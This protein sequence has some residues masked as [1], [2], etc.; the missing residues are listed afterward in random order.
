MNRQT[1]ERTLLFERAPYVIGAASIVAKAEREGPLGSS[2]DRV[3]EDDTFG[4]DSFEKAECRMFETA[5]RDACAGAGL[6]TFDL[7]ALLGGDLLNQ[8]I[9]AN[10]AA[11]NLQ[12][13]FLGLYGACSTMAESLL[14]GGVLADGGYRS[15]VACVACSHF[16]T[17]ER[18]YRYPL[19]MGTTAAPT[20]QRTVTGAGCLLLSDRLLPDV[21]Y[22]HIRVRSAT[23]GKV[24]DLGIDDISNMGAA[25][26]P[27][28]CDTIAQHLMDT[29]RAASDFDR[30][31][32]GDLGTF[33][34]EM[35]LEL[36]AQNGIE[37]EARHF[38]CGE[39][40]Y[41]SEQNYN[42]RGSG[43]GCSAVVLAGH[44]LPYLE[45]GAWKRILFLATGALMS[46]TSNQQGETIPGIA[47][48][49]VLEH[50]GEVGL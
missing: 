7:A 47:H 18:Q 15:P 22:R 26:A 31:V 46:T 24:I 14:L 48:A 45:S 32:T 10:Y 30:I 11:R 34:S 25:M 49:I 12:I 16:S 6:D 40:I 38:D 44:L 50:D 42:C 1:G 29:G 4:E 17:A 20:A 2:F 36:A 43:C 3:L 23:I 27:A 33:G 41:A 8:I 5:V 9:T 19:E 13:P 39:K 28:A 37:L 35:L 21:R